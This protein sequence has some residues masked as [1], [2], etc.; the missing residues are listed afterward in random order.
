MQFW[1]AV[2]SLFL[3][4]GIASPM[5]GSAISVLLEDYESPFPPRLE[6]SQIHPQSKL[7]LSGKQPYEGKQCVDLD[8]KFVEAPGL[9]YLEVVSPHEIRNR[10][11]LLSVAVRGDGSGNGIMVRLVDR[12]GEWHQFSLGKLDFKGWRLL[13]TSLNVPHEHWGGDGNG[14][15]EYPLTFHSIV[16]DSNVRPSQGKIAFDALSIKVEGKP[17]DFVEVYFVPAKPLGY[18]WG[19]GNPPRGKLLVK[20]KAKGP[21]TL[22]VRVV[23]LNHKEEPLGEVWRR[24]VTVSQGKAWEASLPLN[25]RRYGVYF[26]EVALS[27]QSPP[28]SLL[29]EDYEG[30]PPSLG[31][32]QI[33]PQSKVTLSRGEPFQGAQCAELHY[34][35]EKVGGLQYLEVVTPHEITERFNS[36][37]VAVRGDNSNNFVRV[38]FVDKNGEWHQFDL[39]RLDFGGWR[40][41][42]CGLSAPH[43][44]WGGD[45]NGVMEYPITL[46]SIVLDSPV[47]PSE[48]D[49]AFDAVTLWEAPPPQPKRFSICWLPEP[50]PTWKESPFGVCTHFGQFKHKVPD[51]LEL[52]KRMGAG[53]IRD[54]LYWGAIEKEEGKFQP[55]PY[56]DAYMEAVGKLGLQPLIIFSYSNP[57]Y[58][59]GKSPYTAEGVSAF[60]RYCREL[61]T[62]YGK[63]C[64]HWEVW[65]EPNIGFWQPKPNPEHYTNL[66]KA[67]YETVKRADPTA[68]VV[69]VCTA[70]TD[71]RFIEEV[72]KRG[73]GKFMDAISVHPYR[74]P[75]S[76][77]ESD[78]LGEMRNLK[79]LLDKY[80]ASNLK[81]WLTE[82]GYPT[83]RG[84]VSQYRSAMLIVRTFLLALTQ[85]YIERLFLY[86]FQDDGED[87]DYNEHN[88]GL[89]RYDGTPKVAFAGFNTMVRMMA[90]KKFLREWDLGEGVNALEF[91]GEKGKL[92]VLWA[93]KGEREVELRVAKGSVTATD[94]M[95]NGEKLPAPNGIL[96][97]KVSEEPIFL[98]EY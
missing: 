83:H 30:S 96:R 15:L 49:V 11:H 63:I 46:H 72:L 64:K 17:E 9:Q 91:A 79:D 22:E 62:R 97:L 36:L 10:A 42:S 5:E 93:P 53:W 28:R 87:P 33:Q 6:G 50:A 98:E 4:W 85:P 65:N 24:K 82:F 89:I 31:G 34:R 57:N 27:G 3:F 47:R 44:H 48:G 45:N 66:L 51:T 52:L 54:E 59:E 94:L 20:G 95:G 8:Y 92:L 38:R 18:F 55:P 1:F 14:T 70:G 12:N 13:S 37:S 77:E 56:Y 2:L 84:G 74:Y 58:D 60:A 35:F 86:D 40:I 73:G 75:S 19:K 39:G 81:V 29:L 90:R 76:P 80:G 43:G 23:L 78:F 21:A 26:L 16:L 67:V 88:F 7:S 71:L 41:L 68:T 69:G 32:M 25:I 61:V